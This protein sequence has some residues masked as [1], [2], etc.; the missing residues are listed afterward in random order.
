[1]VTLHEF[2]P[3]AGTK[4]SRVIGLSDDIARS[5]SAISARI[6]VILAKLQLVLSFLIKT[7]NDFLREM[8]ESKEYKFSQSAL[9]MILGKD[10]G[11]E[12]VITDL[13]KMPHLLIA[14]TTGSGKSVGFKCDDF[15]FAL[16]FK[17]RW[18]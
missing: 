12:A 4:A 17:T 13:A 1:M 18:V 9:P 11:G 6:A 3:I 5:M 16:S 14:G 2:E 15:I 10:I 7:R 8:L